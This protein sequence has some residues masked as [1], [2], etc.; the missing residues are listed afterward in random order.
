M[1]RILIFLWPQLCAVTFALAQPP[2]PSP[3]SPE[4][5]ELFETISGMDSQLFDA[6]NAHNLDAVMA[7]FSDDVEFYQDN[8][9]VSNY[10]QTK[11]D[12]GKMFASVPDIKR[13]LVKGSLE[14]YPIKD[15]GAIEIGLHR[16]CHK[17]DG[18]GGSSGGLEC[19]SF[20]F[21]HIWHKSGGEWKLT[22]VISYGH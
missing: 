13:E 7:M 1:K 12:F 18:P 21:V 22:R 5:R 16:F 17:Q 11:K 19:G 14:V 15:Y 2:S 6:F 20:K 9:G 8:D 10:E 3:I 4:A